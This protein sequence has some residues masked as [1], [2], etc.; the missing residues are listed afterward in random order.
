MRRVSSTD[1]IVKK[2]RE[3]IQLKSKLI[4]AYEIPTPEFDKLVPDEYYALETKRFLLLKALN[5]DIS[6]TPSLKPS[7]AIDDLWCMFMTCIKEYYKFCNSVISD[8]F[9]DGFIEKIAYNDE[10]NPSDGFE[11]LLIEYK[12][13]FSEENLSTVLW[14]ERYKEKTYNEIV[15]LTESSTGSVYHSPFYESGRSYTD[16]FQPGD[17]ATTALQITKAVEYEVNSV[18]P[19]QRAAMAA[20]QRSKKNAEM[21]DIGKL[22][23]TR[24]RSDSLAE[25]S[26]EMIKQ[27]IGS[28]SEKSKRPRSSPKKNLKLTGSRKCPRCSD[29]VGE[30]NHNK[31]VDVY[32]DIDTNTEVLGGHVGVCRKLKVTN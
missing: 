1:N 20:E 5:H 13:R 19:A 17:T 6:T 23:R 31:F 18:S 12:N 26:P 8:D 15:Q 11:K 22:L 25:S 29:A 3:D 10:R 32:L 28:S 16:S 30:N 7:R 27:Q 2:L 4:V 24:S 21:S 14:N 9:S